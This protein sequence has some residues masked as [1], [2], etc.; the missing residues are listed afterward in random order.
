M[1]E[2]E[3]T[4]ADR[5]RAG[6]TVITGW[7]ILPSPA[8]AEAM[9]RCGYEAVV[10]DMQHGQ[11]DLGSVRDAIGGVVLAGG[12]PVGRIPVDDFATAS[13]MLDLGVQAVIAPMINS[14]ADAERFAGFTKY[15]PTGGRS[16]GPMRAM[17]LSGMEEPQAYLMSADAETLSLGMIE[18]RAGLDALDDI[19]AVKG[20]DGVFVGPGDLSIA[21]SQGA[22][23]D[24]SGA[25]TQDAG[26]RICEAAKKAGKIAGT[27]CNTAEDVKA[28]RAMGYTFIAY[29]VDTVV[30]KTGASAMLGS[31]AV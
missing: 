15:P 6:E 23:I 8:L 25:E 26:R 18:T 13:R 14:V 2:P 12:H 20:L 28:A 16:W 24:P 11:H 30:L 9:V 27:F 3:K 17:E 31:V 29:G 4:L 10:L 1:V 5:L 22:K 19:L 7:S 21:L